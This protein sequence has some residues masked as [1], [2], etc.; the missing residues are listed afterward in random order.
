M[1]VLAALVSRTAACETRAGRPSPANSGRMEALVRGNRGAGG[2]PKG[3]GGQL[4][5]R[6]FLNHRDSEPWVR[7]IRT[8][9]DEIPQDI[10]REETLCGKGSKGVAQGDVKDRPRSVMGGCEV[11]RGT[12]AGK[13]SETTAGPAVRWCS[14]QR[15]GGPCERGGPPRDA[16]P[17][18]RGAAAP[19]GRL[20]DPRFRTGP[21]CGWGARIGCCDRTR[22]RRPRKS[23]SGLTGPG[24]Y[25]FLN[26]L[27]R[28]TLQ[29][30]PRVDKVER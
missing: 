13:V 27:F 12:R 14:G 6:G 16:T 10:L 30:T 26:E 21:N 29:R 20:P 25:V 28:T 3:F 23:S 11:C 4:A 1:D 8:E 15:S 22:A 5:E 18:P 2:H 17:V 19:G 24:L 9:N 7:T